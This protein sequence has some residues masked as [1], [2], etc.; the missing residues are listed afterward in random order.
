[1]S[2]VLIEGY[3]VDEIL[4]FADT[5]LDQ[6]VFCGRPTII[7]AGTAEILGSF[8]ALDD[9]LRLELAHIDGGGEGVLPSVRTLAM[10][11]AKRRRLAHVEWIVHAVSC[12][13]PNLKLRRVLERKGFA[14]ESTHD[15]GPAYRLVESVVS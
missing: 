4:G 6:L 11:I 9:R 7:R 5:D 3:S 13:R 1:M 8:E 2:E 10:A 15:G 12:A 14:V